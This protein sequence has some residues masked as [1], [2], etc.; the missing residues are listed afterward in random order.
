LVKR[1]LLY[2]SGSKSLFSYQPQAQPLHFLPPENESEKK[3]YDAPR[4]DK[5]L[6][7]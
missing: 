7:P 2:I 3:Q 5:T 1:K 6:C 4:D